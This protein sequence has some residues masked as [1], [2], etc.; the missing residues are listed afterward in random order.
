ML[1]EL[2][3][4]L[5]HL[6]NIFASVPCLQLCQCCV[7]YSNSVI[8]QRAHSLR[9]FH[10]NYNWFKITDEIMMYLG[11]SECLLQAAGSTGL[12]GS[13]QWQLRNKTGTEE[14]LSS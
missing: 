11:N 2:P 13:L 3:G 8:K 4:F 1:L 6:P 7:H 12:A 10:I 14:T 9:S 5:S